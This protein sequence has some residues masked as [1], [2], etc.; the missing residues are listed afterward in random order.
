MKGE[1]YHRQG[2]AVAS[3]AAGKAAPATDGKAM[4]ALSG[5][6]KSQRLR[7]LIHAAEQLDDPLNFHIAPQWLWFAPCMAV[8]LLFIAAMSWSMPSI[9]TGA[10]A[11]CATAFVTATRL[12]VS[13]EHKFQEERWHGYAIMLAAMWVPALLFGFAVGQWTYRLESVSTDMMVAALALLSLAATSLLSGRLISVVVVTLGLWSGASFFDSTPASLVALVFGG[14]GGLCI[15]IRE[16]HIAARLRELEAE[17][18]REHRRAGALLSEYEATGQGWFWETDRH[19]M[20]AYVSPRIA[21]L[22]GSDAASLIGTPFIDLFILDSQDPETERT[23][24]FH[25][26][27]RSSFQDLAAHAA[28]GEKEE[29]WW[30]VTGRPVLDKFNNFLGF[31]GSGT[32]LT[33]ARKSQ[34][35]V[36]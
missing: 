36:T 32:D 22:V 17:R 34:R 33:E 27:T 10:I 26:S 25:L 2:T 23:L 7:S 28:T 11:L 13:L 9:S 12:F 20:I 5:G 14:M 15:S 21:K 31:R 18:E 1:S 8:T 35:H 16:A 19:G 30:S 3:G 4:S 24:V 6:Q 29:R